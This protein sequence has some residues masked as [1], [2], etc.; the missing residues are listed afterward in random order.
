M[1]GITLM[2][3]ADKAVASAMSG[4]VGGTVLNALGAIPTEQL[5]TVGLQ[6]AGFAN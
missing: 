1:L 4:N 2:V 6:Q 5:A 3:A